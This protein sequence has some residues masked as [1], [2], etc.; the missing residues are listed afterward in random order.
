MMINDPTNQA[1]QD[2][3]AQAHAARRNIR[4]LISWL[5]TLS[6]PRDEAQTLRL[7]IAQLQEQL[8]ILEG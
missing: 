4:N 7:Q 5:F 8:V 6:Q 1:I 3:L 2:A